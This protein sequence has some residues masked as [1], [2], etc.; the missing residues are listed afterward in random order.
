MQETAARIKR[1]VEQTYPLILD[2][3][4]LRLAG[5]GKSGEGGT[6]QHHAKG[7]VCD[8][9]MNLP[10]QRPLKGGPNSDEA[11]RAVRVILQPL[12]K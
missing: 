4:D 2:G 11:D 8:I 12:V 1:R 10:M 7:R 5:P 3:L 9:V 6:A